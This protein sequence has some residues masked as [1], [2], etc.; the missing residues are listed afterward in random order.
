MNSDSYKALLAIDRLA[1]SR[2]DDS[3]DLRMIREAI[4]AASEALRR[5]KIAGTMKA[6]GIVPPR[7]RAFPASCSGVM[8]SG[9]VKEQAEAVCSASGEI[10]V[11]RFPSGAITW[12][13]RGG[14]ALP[15]AEFI[16]SYNDGADWRRVVEDL[17]A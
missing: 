9:T 17:A 10:D 3:G 1:K 8:V 13:K 15:N 11:Y 16:G 14:S 6:K 5:A 7:R 4:L 12:R 2:P